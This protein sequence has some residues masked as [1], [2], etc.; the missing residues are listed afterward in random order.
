MKSI[1]IKV[2]DEKVNGED[3]TV[4]LIRTAV[5]NTPPGGFEVTDM[6]NRLKLGGIL[7]KYE[8]SKKKEKRAK[9][10]EAQEATKKNADVTEEEKL[11]AEEEIPE[12]EDM[13]LKPTE[14]DGVLRLEDAL[15]EKLGGYITATKWPFMSQSIVDFVELFKEDKK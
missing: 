10:V 2:T 12:A 5:N 14:L 6:M 4:S 9:L 3:S 8:L 15:F 1:I 13:K 11:K 7:D